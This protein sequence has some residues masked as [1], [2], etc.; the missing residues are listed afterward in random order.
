MTASVVHV[1]QADTPQP[2][3]LDVVDAIEAAGD[4]DHLQRLRIA[5][6]QAV[7]HRGGEVA[8]VRGEHRAGA[9]ALVRLG[10]VC[11]RGRVGRE[12]CRVCVG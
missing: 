9:R 4:G 1:T 8:A 5:H 11:V 12:R 10:E 7:L 2:Y 3:P 6:H